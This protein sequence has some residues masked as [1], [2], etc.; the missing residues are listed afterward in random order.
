MHLKS[1]TL[2]GFKS[3]A[4]A[5]T[6]RFEP[7]ITCVVG[8][9]GSGKSNVV[10]ALSWV[11]GE[12]GAKSLRGGKMEDVIFA[13]TTGRPPLGRAEVSLTIDNADGALPIDYAEV[14]ITRIMFR[15][16]GSEYQINGDT[17]RLLD[18]QELLS[19][20]GIGREMH[21]IVG[22]GQLDGVLHA[23]PTGRRA[24]IEEAAGVLKHR[25]RKEKALRKL[26]AMQANLARVQDLTDELRRQLK[27]LGRQAAV[28][29]RAAVIQADL[30]D[31]RLRLLADDLVT[32]REALSAEIADEAE[33]KRRKEAAEADLRTAQQREAALE[34]QVRR[35]APRLRDAQQ[36]WYELSQLAERVRGTIS[37]AD[38]RVKSATSAPGEER[39]GRDPEDMEREAARIREQEAELEAA[40]EAASRALEDTVAHRAELERGLA[41][42]ER[43]LKDV[44]RAI[45]DR[46]EGLARLQGQVNAARSRAGSAGAEIERLAASRDEAQTRAVAAQEEYEQLKAEVDGLDADDAELAERHEAAKRELAEAETALSAAREAATAAERERAATS[47]RHDALALG[48]RRKDGTGALLA[49]ADRLGGLLGPA[50]ELLTVT[51]GFEVP[52]AAALGAAADAIAVTGPRAAAEAI[53]LL[54]TDDAGR[55]ALLLT[56]AAPDH[57]EPG[58][59]GAPRAASGEP[60]PGGAA[61]VPGTRAEGAVPGEPGQVAPPRSA[62]APAAAGSPASPCAPEPGGS[63][64][65]GA[66]GANA[67]ASTAGAGSPAAAPPPNGRAGGS[68]DAGDGAP[69]VPGTRS[70]DGPVAG[71]SGSDDG[72]RPGGI[73][74][75]SGAADAWGAASGS[76]GPGAPQA[77]ADTAGASPDAGD[78]A[79]PG[80]RAPGTD[81]ASRGDTGAAS[82][83]AGPGADRPVVP[84]TRPEATGDEGRDPHTASDGAPPASEPGATVAAVGGPSG[85]ATPAVSARVPHPAGGEATV[86][87]AVP[88]GA[89]TR[90]EPGKAA[91][92]EG[93][94]WVADLVAGPAALLPAVRRL[95]DGMVVVGTLEEAEE[96]LTR[97]PE[98]T[99]VTAEGDLLGA[100]FAQGGSAGAPTLLEVQASVD[101]AA[102]QLE[103]LAVRCEELAGAQ[104]AAKERR[105]ECLALVE[106]LGGRRSAADREK[107][108]VAQSLGRLAGQARGAVG[109]AE[110]SAAAVARAEEA[111]ERATGEAEELA[112]RL[113]VA[114][115]QP[116]EEEPDT[117]VRDRLAADGANARQTEMEARLQVRTHEERVK[118]LAG[119]ADALDRGARA[120]R[121]A[122]ARAEQLRARLRHEAQVASAVA[123][124][125]R[126]LLA[127]VEV[128]LVR[129]G[130]ER[131]AAERAKAERERELDTARGQ[132]RD[133]KSEL[134]KLT[135]SVHRGEVLGA[136]KRMRIEQLESKALEELGV[137]PAG[138]IAEYGPDQ[139]VPPSPPAEGEVL[140]EDPEHPRNQPVRYVRAQQEKRLKAAER[141][142]QQL[143]KVNPLALEEFA[144]LEERHQFLSEQLEDLKKTRADLL[145]VVKEVDERVEQVFT[146]AY[147]DTAREFEGVFS[148]L[149]P[150]GE[151]RLVLTDPENMLT[152]GV[153]VEARPPGK[154]VKRLSLLSGGERSLTAVALLVSIFKARPSPFY[155]MDEVEAALDDTNLQRLIR[156]M[157]ELQE[158]SQ[159][160]V[161]TH[162]KRT[163]EVAD[164]LYGVSM[165]GDGVSKVISQR[166]R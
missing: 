135:D 32:L 53:R 119:R 6:L 130:Q 120:E 100:H 4:S 131:D 51:S 128:S 5:T 160:I 114:E 93:S 43:R 38:A 102:A 9:N 36:T 101:E 143:G 110:R 164:A 18:I 148:R 91:T 163:M 34:E 94:P 78:G 12:Q 2:R 80:T 144:A 147:Q 44:A 7:G 137:E 122:R 97:R 8:P 47:A 90:D 35:L 126:Q 13:G 37:L 134:D 108:R 3:F 48:L 150:G 162:Q 52:V 29:R 151:G 87:G 156:I 76:G 118:G 39:R 123:S 157:Q 153:D 99:T 82:T 73:G 116:G 60:A 84:G 40:L 23:D 95:L 20:S 112:E 107:S 81:A 45:A 75:P 115:E 28:A 66:L 30:R 10:D 19:D 68:T 92:A 88:E 109:E 79:A 56:T 165:Q 154:K 69:A 15:N 42:E 124:G 161:I 125:A 16:G 11:M 55:A 96:L 158:A 141:A 117:S 86:P 129:A 74:E 145:Q 31:A 77:V 62:V 166:L 67:E 152:T 33:L 1:L 70:P 58:G 132:G 133:L 65:G 104:R 113:A 64:A 22:Q 27:P 138:L 26:D 14:T 59:S 149:F 127:H 21:V 49:A 63:E 159:L 41:D 142:Y 136:E 50:A 103:R 140:P 46:R 83:S 71:S 25:K 111:L 54:R 85:S 146:E 72:S 105:A 121:E 24:F 98:L 106:E 139:L 57:A 89:A 17:C 61:L 155:V